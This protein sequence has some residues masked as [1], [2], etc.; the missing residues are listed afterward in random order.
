[1]RQPGGLSGKS[2]MRAAAADTPLAATWVALWNATNRDEGKIARAFAEFGEDRAVRMTLIAMSLRES[3]ELAGLAKE[4]FYPPSLRFLVWREWARDPA[5]EPRI[6]AEMTALHPGDPQ[7]ATVTGEHPSAAERAAWLAE[8]APAA[9]LR[10]LCAA[11]CPENPS[12][13]LDAAFAFRAGPISRTSV[14]RWRSLVP[15]AVWELSPRGRAMILR[16]TLPL[17]PQQRDRKLPKSLR[18]MPASARPS[19]LKTTA[20]R[21][22]SSEFSPPRGPAGHQRRLRADSS[23][24]RALGRRRLCGQEPTRPPGLCVK[25][26]SPGQSVQGPAAMLMRRPRGLPMPSD[27][28]HPHDFHKNPFVRQPLR[29]GIRKRSS[30]KITVLDMVSA[31]N[32]TPCRVAADD[33]RCRRSMNSLRRT[34]RERRGPDAKPLRSR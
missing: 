8:A 34:D 7:I 18:W 15:S 14:V 27:A 33:Q 26:F 25:S 4:P 9:P 16:L 21:I 13:C 32:C 20:T 2:W 23:R 28:R 12:R 1:M 31:S 3:E 24:S 11:T 30:P 19:P 22:N 6:A 5:S 10:A 17:D 29:V